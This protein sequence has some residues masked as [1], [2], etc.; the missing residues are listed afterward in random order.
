M[1]KRLEYKLTFVYSILIFSLNSSIMINEPDSMRTPRT[2]LMLVE[3]TEI[4]AFKQKII[5]D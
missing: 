4:R 1:C 2:L 5:S 3:K